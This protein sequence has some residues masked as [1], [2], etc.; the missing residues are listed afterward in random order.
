MLFDH[1]PSACLS[2]LSGGLNLVRF[3]HVG[4]TEQNSRRI[5]RN[6]PHARN[7]RWTGRPPAVNEIPVGLQFVE[8]V[9]DLEA[10][11]VD[12]QKLHRVHFQ[13][14]GEK[15]IYLFAGSLFGDHERDRTKMPI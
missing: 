15:D 6:S 10:R 7:A 5:R 4:Q 12:F 11:R 8:G 14:G 2:C 3:A 1:Q 9:F 13:I